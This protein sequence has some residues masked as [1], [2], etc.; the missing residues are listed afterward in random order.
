MQ[1]DTTTPQSN[2]NPC[3]HGQHQSMTTASGKAKGLQAV[4]QER[5]FDIS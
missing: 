5:G 3:F 2:P 4:L 1:C